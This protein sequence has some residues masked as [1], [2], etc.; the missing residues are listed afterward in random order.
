MCH[1]QTFVLAR[2]LLRRVFLRVFLLR[3]AEMA[4]FT[5]EGSQRLDGWL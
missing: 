3:W 1:K 5:P 4:T 2:A